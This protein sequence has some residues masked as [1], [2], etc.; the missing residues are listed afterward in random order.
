LALA[1]AGFRFVPVVAALAAFTF[2]GFFFLG[3]LAL[4]GFLAFTAFATLGLVAL[5]DFADA[6]ACGFFTD[7]VLAVL[8]FFSV[9][10]F[11]I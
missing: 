3:A 7:F 11:I 8:A 4:T 1:L 10:F 5:R 2:A 6:V 9:F